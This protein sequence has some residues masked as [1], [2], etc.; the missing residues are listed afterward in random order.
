MGGFLIES[1]DPV[2]VILS[3]VVATI[4]SF[5]SLDLAGQVQPGQKS[6]LLWLLCG[7]AAMGTGIWSMHF[8]AIL[9][10]HFPWP[11]TYSLWETLLSLIYAMT[12]SGIALGLLRLGS[13]KWYFW[14]SGGVVM[15]AA[16]SGMHYTGMMALKMPVQMTYNWSIVGVSVGIAIV[17]SLASLW[18]ASW[19]SQPQVSGLVWKKAVAALVMAIAISGMHYTGMAAM[20]FHSPLP[21]GAT[22]LDIPDQPFWLGIAVGIGTLLV[23]S[24]ALSASLY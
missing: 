8:V 14:A 18:L 12:A 6:W 4:A 20:Q 23:L 2:L 5:S 22:V 19:L 24:L 11:V 17:A 9:A 21:N 13:Q 10:I 15:G 3:F 1:H 16:I 7:S